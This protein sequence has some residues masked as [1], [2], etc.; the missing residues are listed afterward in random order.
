MLRDVGFERLERV[1]LTPLWKRA[2]R[3]ARRLLTGKRDFLAPLRQGRVV[4]HGW[5]SVEA[6]TAPE[7]NGVK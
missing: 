2:G 4:Y 1:Y 3:A 6:G 7:V 5:K